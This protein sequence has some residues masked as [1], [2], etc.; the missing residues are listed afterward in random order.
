MTVELLISVMNHVTCGTWTPM[1]GGARCRHVWVSDFAI[2]F[3]K[4]SEAFVVALWDAHD[5]ARAL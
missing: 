4:N 3:H 5:K 2:K 1:R